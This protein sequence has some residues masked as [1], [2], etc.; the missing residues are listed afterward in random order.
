MEKSVASAGNDFDRLVDLVETLR[1]ERGCPWDQVQTPETI[2]VYL[3]EEAYEVL[4]AIESGT[5]KDICAELGDL[6]FH[7]VFLARIFEECGVFNAKDIIRTITE[8]MIRRHPHVFGEV[9]LSN[10]EEVRKQWHEIKMTE[11]KEKDET[12]TSLLDS[13]P[14]N[15]PALMRAY[16]ISERA[17]KLG[18]EL[19]DIESLLKKLDEDLA[20][21]KSAAKR[22][23]SEESA[24]TLG[25]LLFTIVN[26]GRA[27]RV[28][29]ESALT[30]AISRF[31]TRF[32]AVERTV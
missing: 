10:A 24:Q 17:G 27:I 21:F 26:L 14:Q 8:K 22:P 32:N 29:P 20:E 23:D 18:F 31:V 15:L 2:K 13:V 19:P 11:A 6:L 5:H 3:I 25:D 30:R 16:R 9:R 12:K 4:E 28:H 1:S 7:I